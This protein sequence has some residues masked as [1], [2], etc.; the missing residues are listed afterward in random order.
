MRQFP[1]QVDEN[2]SGQSSAVSYIPEGAWNEP[3]SSSGGKITYAASATGGGASAYIAKPSWQTGTGVPADGMR[4]VPDV[5]LSSATHDGY[6]ACLAYAGG[7][8]SKQEFEVFGGT[9]AAAPGV[10]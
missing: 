3:T 8:C 2:G 10:M 6:L 7:D 4:D 1:H 9:S 5:A